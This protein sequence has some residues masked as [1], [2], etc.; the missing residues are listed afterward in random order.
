MAIESFVKRTQVR[1]CSLAGLQTWIM[2]SDERAL[3]RLFH[4]QN[5]QMKSERSLCF[6]IGDRRH[7]GGHA[8]KS[9]TPQAELLRPIEHQHSSRASHRQQKEPAKLTTFVTGIRRFMKAYAILWQKL[10]ARFSDHT[11]DQGNRVLVSRVATHLDAGDRVSMQTGRL[12]QILNRPIQ[13]ST[14]H[15]NLCASHRLEAVPLPHAPNPQSFLPYR[16][17]KGGSNDFQII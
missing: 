12:S 15:P 14:R 4:K 8:A 7:T 9:P 5:A 2:G 16:R 6:V 11:L 3:V 17:I 10:H 1:L 13:R